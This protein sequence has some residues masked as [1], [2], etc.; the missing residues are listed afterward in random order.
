MKFGFEEL[1]V[2]DLALE[3]IDEVYGIA[4]KFPPLELYNLSSQL[5]RAAISV[6]LNIAEGSGRHQKKDFARFVR[7]SIGSL[8][9]VVAALKVAIRRNYITQADYD[10]SVSPLLEK[11]YFK[12]IALEKSL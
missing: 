3:M 5:R 7:L 11:L 9:E 8:L 10:A 6:S 1:E 12:L 2:W 4:E